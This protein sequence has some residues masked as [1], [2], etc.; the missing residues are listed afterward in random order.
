MSW[1]EPPQA[2]SFGNCL[3]ILGVIVAFMCV[4]FVGLFLYVVTVA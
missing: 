3:G 4:G 2:E 1:E